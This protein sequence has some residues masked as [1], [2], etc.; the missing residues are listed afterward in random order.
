MYSS[1]LIIFLLLLYGIRVAHGQ[2][3]VVVHGTNSNNTYSGS[4]SEKF[5]SVSSGDTFVFSSDP[6]AQA[7]FTFTGLCYY[8]HS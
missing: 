4:W 6:G 1:L 2:I 7:T 3:T 5:R 8:S